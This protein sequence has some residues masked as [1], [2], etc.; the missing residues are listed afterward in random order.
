MDTTS[1]FQWTEHAWTDKKVAFEALSVCHQSLNFK[2]QKCKCKY[3]ETD[4]TK[5]TAFNNEIFG[6]NWPT[7]I[8]IMEIFVRTLNTVKK[9]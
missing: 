1:N 6:S 8:T 7:N 4:T 3:P 5:Y 9:E 2:M